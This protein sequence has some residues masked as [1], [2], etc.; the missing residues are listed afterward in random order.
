M[1][2]ALEV[3]YT[4]LE[5][6]V[7]GLADGTLTPL[8]IDPSVDRVN[9]VPSFS[10]LRTLRRRLGRRIRPDEYRSARL[11]RIDFSE[12]TDAAVPFASSSARLPA[13]GQGQLR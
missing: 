7:C 6:V 3:D 4:L 1:E 5:H 9:T 10:E 13:T 2:R 11:Q 12:G 8:S